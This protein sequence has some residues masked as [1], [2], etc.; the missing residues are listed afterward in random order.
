MVHRVGRGGPP[1]PMTPTVVSYTI[2]ASD[3]VTEVGGAWGRCA[4]E[5]NA[6]GLVDGA[7]GRPL[8]DFISDPATR[9]IYHDLLACVRGGREA[10]FPY[11]CD[12]V[13]VRREM[14]MRIRPLDL[15]RVHFEST[16]VAESRYPNTAVPPTHDARPPFTRICSWCKR[17]ALGDGWLELD[18]AIERLELFA[19]P[20]SVQI[21]HAMCPSCA[22][23]MNRRLLGLL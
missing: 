15:G 9:Q 17:V 23:D 6:A 3:I 7:V 1:A 11:R 13:R 20:E 12:D 18:A 19:A 4:L 5:G 16:V 14:V 2:D 10:E 22:A 21:T 8:W